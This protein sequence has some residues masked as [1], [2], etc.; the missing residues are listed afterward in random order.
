MYVGACVLVRVWVS[1]SVYL[2]CHVRVVVCVGS[3][4]SAFVGE[5]VW[6]RGFESVCGAFMCVCMRICA[7]VGACVCMCSYLG[8]C[9]CVCVC[10]CLCVCVFVCVCV[11]VCVWVRVCVCVCVCVFV[12]A[13]VCA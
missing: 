9:V 6:V 5:C 11:C 10:V 12:R 1:V 4:V 13:C 8:A 3:R 7:C 2:D